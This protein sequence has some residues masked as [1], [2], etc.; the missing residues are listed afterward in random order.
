[1]PSTPK[2]FLTSRR[3]YSAIEDAFLP[4]HIVR[5]LRGLRARGYEAY[6]RPPKPPA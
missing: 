2:A 5:L 3:Q 4:A 1:M 6:Y